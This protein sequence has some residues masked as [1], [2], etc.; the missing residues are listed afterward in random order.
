MRT[1]ILL[2]I[3]LIN[4][5]IFYSQ[6]DPC[7]TTQLKYE[8][9]IS[10][11]LSEKDP[12]KRL[13]KLGDIALD[14]PQFPKTYF[15]LAELT[16]LEAKD[17]SKS[18]TG[19]QNEVYN[20]QKKAN[21]FYAA[22]ILKC[23]YYHASCYFNIA[24]NFISMG[25]TDAAIPY[26][27]KYIDFPEDDLSKLEDDFLT[28]KRN[29]KS[30]L[31]ELE[32]EK[33]L[34][35]NP[36][37]FNPMKVKNV[38]SPLDEYFPMISPDN[39]LLFFSRK[40][41][42]K[43]LGDISDNIQEELTLALKDESTL[44]F[45]YGTPLPSPF[46]NGSFFNYGTTTLSV[47]NKEMIV[48][49][50]K[51]EIVSNQYYL[52]CDLYISY[53]KRKGI[54]GNDFEWSP[55]E[56]M[57]PNINTPDGW[58]A[59][60]TLSADGKLLFFTSARKGTRDNDIFISERQNDGSWSKAVPFEFI[61][62]SGKDKSPFFHQDGETLYFVS[63]TSSDRKGAGGLDIFYIRKKENGWTQPVNIGFPINS[64]DDELGI[65]VSTSGRIAY[66]SS[67]KEGEWNIYSFD[68]YEQAR[69]QEVIIV[70]GN[71]KNEDGTP[72]ENAVVEINYNESG[73]TQQFK[74]NGD[75]GKFAAVVKVNN[76]QDV[77]ISFNKTDYAF[78]AK[79]IEQKD[80]ELAVD[81]KLKLGEFVLE[82]IE[83]GRA[84]RLADI[85]FETDSYELNSKSKALLNS[86]A[87]FLEKNPN[88]KVSINGHTDDKGDDKINL[89]LSQNRADQVKNYLIDKGIDPYRLNA[90]GFGESKPSLPNKSDY[91]R[92]RNRRTEFEFI[93]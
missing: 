90:K 59:Q 18:G 41:N 62:T 88:L 33:N 86:F 92:S 4:F 72:V 78:Q 34:F 84:Y 40:V 14:F 31:E 15:I 63:T 8:K 49:A 21:V 16:L 60:P 79:V 71:L 91:N 2:I 75:D 89:I 37:P 6:N 20:L 68:L 85:F 53:Y 46:N 93:P 55:L 39:D 5:S 43:N 48:C 50:C 26:L 3:I 24:E 30:L 64:V 44:E 70:K 83:P 42:R 32:F 56:N 66:F 10:K 52:N 38:S 1:T 74:V 9:K 80:L 58:E 47:D 17:K 73:E 81:S 61:N 82:E 57:G 23:P 22:T 76:K 11:A 12:T 77:T 67:L 27:K 29:S 51:K 87:H 35:N 65:F 69:P 7:S 28:K 54:G 19:K 13:E 36:V 45:N 25:E